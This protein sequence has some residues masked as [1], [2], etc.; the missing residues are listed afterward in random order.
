MP[1]F[2]V[3]AVFAEDI[4]DVWL[5]S[6]HNMALDDLILEKEMLKEI[7]LSALTEKHLKTFGRK[8]YRICKEKLGLDVIKEMNLFDPEKIAKWEKAP[9]WSSYHLRSGF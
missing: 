6:F 5:L 9:I 3:F 7:W 4:S 1:D 8:A 2:I